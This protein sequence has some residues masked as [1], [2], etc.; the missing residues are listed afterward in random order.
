MSLR[1]SHESLVCK[2]WWLP[3]NIRRSLETKVIQ[4]ISFN[5]S[6]HCREVQVDN[7]SVSPPFQD[8]SG[9]SLGL[10]GVVLTS[11]VVSEGV[12]LYLSMSSSLSDV[13]PC[14]LPDS[15][16]FLLG[17]LIVGWAFPVVSCG[18]VTSVSASHKIL[19]RFNFDFETFFKAFQNNVWEV[20]SIVTSII[21][22]IEFE[23]IS[24]GHQE[25]PG[26]NAV[27]VEVVKQP[28]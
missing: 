15:W 5:L 17:V 24:S 9:F 27:F 3:P 12:P 14:S 4:E 19:E 28:P 22:I 7:G 11:T 26:G 10:V 6:F 1:G 2:N 21:V 25:F 20:L 23:L 13:E 16:A 8:P 18:M